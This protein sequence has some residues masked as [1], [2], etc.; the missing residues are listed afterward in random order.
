MEVIAT[1]IPDVKLVRPQVFGDERGFLLETFQRKVFLEQGLPGEFV[2]ENH[3]RSRQAVLRGLHYQIRQPQGKLIRVAFGEVF[4][5]AVD[6]RRSSPHFGRWV[7]TRLSDRNHEMLWIPPGFGHGFV[8][9]SESVDLIYKCTD[10]YAPEHE[11]IIAWDDPDIGV[12]WP[13]PAGAEPILSAKDK[14]GTPFRS[15]DT[16]P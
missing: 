14:V 9:L 12:D 1:A 2:Q 3:S 8:T 10:F 11:R 15:A 5:V 16:Y 7:G 13:L 6:L 4:D